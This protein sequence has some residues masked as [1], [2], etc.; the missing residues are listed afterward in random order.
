MM[1]IFFRAYRSTR[2]DA[3]MYM[4][5]ETFCITW[6]CI[7]NQ[8]SYLYIYIYI[9]SYLVPSR[10]IGMEA[11][12]LGDSERSSRLAILWCLKYTTH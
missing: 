7:R 1:I 11:V 12:W 6:T 9:I 3:Y 4:Y 2:V 8:K 5:I 10:L